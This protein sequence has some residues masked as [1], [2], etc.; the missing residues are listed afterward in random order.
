MVSRSDKVRKALI[1]EISDL[2][3]RQIKDP[4]IAGIVS[5]SDVEVSSDCRH[6]KIFVSVYGSE[7]ERSSTMEAL[8]SSTGFIRSEVGKRI[9][10]RFTPEIKF[11]QDDSLER[12]S[13]VTELIN[14]ISQGEL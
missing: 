3:Q 13:R 14:K 11:K 8:E 12:G 10:M 7:E 1:R 2:L 5:V 4:R 9:P 6:A